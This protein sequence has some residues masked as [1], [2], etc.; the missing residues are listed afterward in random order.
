MISHHTL[1]D[2]VLELF[3]VDIKR[4]VFT[5]KASRGGRK[6][7]ET[8]GT[9]RPDGYIQISIDNKCYLAHQLVLLVATGEMPQIV[10]HLN[11]V[12]S[13]NRYENL[14]PATPL[15]NS[16]NLK[17]RATNEHGVAGVR[18]RRSRDAFEAIWREAPYVVRH[19]YFSCA[20]FGGYES[21]RAAAIRYRLDRIKAANELGAGYTARH[22]SGVSL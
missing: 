4:G 19:K 20:K 9:V 13:D 11:G 15:L 12:K 21:A 10:D 5:R 7:G 6:A 22:C 17:V 3:D 18:Y 14:R 8:A 16:R 2:R 1:R